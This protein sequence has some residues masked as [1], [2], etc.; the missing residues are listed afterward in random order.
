MSTSPIPS[1]PHLDWELAAR[2]DFGVD[3]KQELLALT[4]PRRRMAR[5][6]ELLEASLE[7]LR[8]EQTPPRTRRPERQGHAAR[9]GV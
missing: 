3:P 9:P 4:S 5:L 7:A 2:V 6:V 8:L 1:S